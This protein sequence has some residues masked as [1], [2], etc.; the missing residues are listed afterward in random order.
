M[1][2]IRRRLLAWLLPA[3]AATLIAAAIT[4]YTLAR[5]EVDELFDY[6]LRVTADAMRDQSFASLALDPV[7]LRERGE[8]EVLVQ[9]WDS[10]RGI[11]FASRHDR[12]L[13]LILET[14]FHN[15]AIAGARY[16]VYSLVRNARLIQ[17][18][19]P[20][21]LRAARSA[22]IALRNTFPFAILL[23][24]TLL[25]AWLAVGGGLRPLERLAGELRARSHESL[26]PL[27]RDGLPGELLPLVDNLNDLL[28]RLERANRAQ[29]DFIA[30]AAHELRSPMTALRLQLDLAE[31]GA[32]PGGR[33]AALATLRE[34][35]DR[36]IRLVEQLLM[37]ARLD[38]EA[39]QRTE[40]VD[41]VS[42]A[43]EVVAGRAVLAESAGV[44]LGL[45]GAEPASVKGDAN[46]LAVL[47]GNLVDNGLRHTPRDGRVDVAV[48]REGARALLEVIDDGPGI[49]AAERVRVFDRFFRG[50]AGGAAGS[51][52]G[53]A[54]VR[55]IADRHG[56]EVR[57][58]DG[59]PGRG[60][61]ARVV[62]PAAAPEAAPANGRSR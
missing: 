15:V 12:Q 54:I 30:D 13:P 52:L 17:V 40:P 23:P 19:Q 39:P 36:S 49:P 7:P 59:P 56:A 22:E 8:E 6:H 46:A 48:R 51:G 37:L 34:G 14:G 18:A 29:R 47:L 2:T 61:A 5:S 62:F 53:L 16:R 4:S 33:A 44:D 35:L 9:I 27:G 28:A 38:P 43:R 26:A 55:R 42:V 58:E 11:V 41:L 10:A 60:L 24:L 57:L 32:G 31:H 20:T 21:A 25:L 45:A 3:L 50:E 1:N